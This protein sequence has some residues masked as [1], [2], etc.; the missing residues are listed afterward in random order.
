MGLVLKQIHVPQAWTGPLVYPKQC[1][2]DMRF[3]T[4]DVRSLYRSGSLTSVARELA[5]YT[6]D[7]VGVQEDRWDKWGSVR[8]GDYIFLFCGKWNRIHPLGSE[9]FVHHRIIS[10]AKRVEFVSNRMSYIILRAHRCNI[11]VVNVH[12]PSEEKSDESKDSCC[13]EL[14]QVFFLSFSKVPYESSVRKC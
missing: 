9:F 3:G 12:A 5:R 14:E 6:L 4:W 13:E 10:A 11:I 8:T 2:R 1:K 7:L